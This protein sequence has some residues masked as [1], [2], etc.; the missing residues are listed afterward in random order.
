MVDLLEEAKKA[1]A[2]NQTPWTPEKVLKLG[3]HLAQV[4]NRIETLSGAETSAL[5][6]ETVMKVLEE[7]EKADGEQTPG[8]T[9]LD[10]SKRWTELRGLVQTVLP[11]TLTLIVG[12]AR[13]KFDLQKAA[14][15]ASAAAPVVASC[16]ASCF[17]ALWALLKG[18]AAAAAAAA[19][20][21][22]V[23]AQ[24]APQ[25]PQPTIPNPPVAVEPPKE[26]ESRAAGE[27]SQESAPLPAIAEEPGSVEEN[28]P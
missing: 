14:E 18:P 11:T 2:E 25:V 7:A 12:A 3:A 19:A 16:A 26:S 5:V 24:Q 28:R 4:V 22:P 8:S 15:V 23:A 9:G 20:V 21:P 6:C 13:G 17:P 1:L 27:A 10:C